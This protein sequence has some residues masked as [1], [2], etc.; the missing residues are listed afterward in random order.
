MEDE[1]QSVTLELDT[2]R[3]LCIAIRVAKHTKPPSG[4]KTYKESRAGHGNDI[5]RGTNESV[6]CLVY[7]S[8]RSCTLSSRAMRIGVH[9]GHDITHPYSFGTTNATDMMLV[10][11]VVVVDGS[12][13]A[14]I[15][16]C[17]RTSVNQCHGD[18]VVIYVMK[19][20]YLSVSLKLQPVHWTRCSRLCRRC[21]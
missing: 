8:L 1:R 13:R 11:V 12:C 17:W 16:C 2:Y 15:L 5:A 4:L 6:Q 7:R 9:V 10:V 21:C 3:S 18:A 14:W 20:T 19:Q